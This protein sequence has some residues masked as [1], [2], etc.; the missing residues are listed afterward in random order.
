M[1]LPDLAEKTYEQG[2]ALYSLRRYPE[3][4]KML[5][6]AL[7]HD[8]RHARSHAYLALS[9]LA[10]SSSASPKPAKLRDALDEARRAVAA[11]PADEFPFFVL[12]WACLAN[13][14]EADALK[15][16]QDGLRINP[17]SA[18]GYVIYGQVHLRR[19]EWEKALQASTYGLGLDPSQTEL[20]N[21][22]A[23]A[24]IML[25]RLEEARQAVELALAWD[26]SS[27]EAHLNHGWLAL[28]EG[29]HPAALAHF[30]EALR[31]DPLSEAARIGF[32]Q[33]LK[34]RNVLYRLL[35]RYSLWSSRLTHSESLAF[36]VLLA[37]LDRG[38][39]L[40]AGYFPPFW[41]VYIPLALL[42]SIFI[43]FSWISDSLFYLLM[44]F[45]RN[46]RLLLNRDE[47]A[48]SNAFGACLVVILL[49]LVGGLV[50]WKWGFLAGGLM[51]AMMLMPVASIFRLNPK[52]QG[53]RVFL[54][55]LVT[56]MGISAA[57]GQTG[58]LLDA[59]WLIAPLGLFVIGWFL[60]PWI[61]NLMFLFE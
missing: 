45:D 48:A 31:L 13:R 60:Y 38:L 23:Y 1:T 35:V 29:D 55:V 57:C 19:R 24:L 43:F 5:R 6:Q 39:R 46:G 33:A 28:F 16:A 59:P 37:S 44:R 7:A 14:R 40:F 51:A 3:A 25:A 17:Q 26:P 49:N 58:L 56:W 61:A 34:S 21:Q 52:K 22:R 53:R 32:I 47:I 42:Y 2:R 50:F 20:L 4:E 12:A 41:A 10:Q 27:D 18:W 54:T 11:G 15:A 9:L 8:P 30:R 36:V